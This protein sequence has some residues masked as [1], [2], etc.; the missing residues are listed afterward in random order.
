MFGGIRKWYAARRAR[1]RITH[2]TIPL[3]IPVDRRA[4]LAEELIEHFYD[5]DYGLLVRVIHR[6]S[7]LDNVKL[8]RA[9]DVLNRAVY[10]IKTNDVQ[11][12][13]LLATMS[14]MLVSPED[15][16]DNR[17]VDQFRG[18]LWTY[19][20]WTRCA[21]MRCYAMVVYVETS[22]GHSMEFTE[23]EKRRMQLDLN[24]LVL[25]TPWCYDVAAGNVA[26]IS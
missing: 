17:Y 14:R 24:T 20:V 23:A 9:S 10:S 3:V 25:F 16:P 21:L 8:F 18:F 15:D 19:I 2:M 5:L 6:L 13:K 22:F 11:R 1:H 12:M 4:E 7:R 26:R